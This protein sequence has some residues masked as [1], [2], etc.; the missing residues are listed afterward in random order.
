MTTKEKILLDAFNIRGRVIQR[1][2]EIESAIDIY[3]VEYFSN[4][5]AKQIE[6]RALIVAPRMTFEN[7]FQV[8]SYLVNKYHPEFES[9][10]KNYKK[11]IT[12]IIEKRNMFAHFPI[13]FSDEALKAYEKDGTITFVKLKNS[14]EFGI[15]TS[16]SIQS[17]YY[18]NLFSMMGYYFDAIYK[19]I[20]PGTASPPA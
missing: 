1:A 2:I 14:K 5:L 17:V 19:L 16:I 20:G 13:D 12:Y 7:K 11:D 18:N 8:F 9:E 4:D 6:L 15:S 3:I 10:H